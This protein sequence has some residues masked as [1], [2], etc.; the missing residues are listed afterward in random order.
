MKIRGTEIRDEVVAEIGRFAILWNYFEKDFCMNCCN[1][2]KIKEVK[3]RIAVEPEKIDVFLKV[4]S[5][6]RHHFGFNVSEYIRTGLYPG[7]ARRTGS[8][9]ES[10]MRDFM[11]EIRDNTLDGCL[12]I[13]YRIRNNLM[14]G[15]KLPKDLNDQLELFQSANEVLESIKMK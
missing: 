13:I 15:L 12:L 4:L 10:C 6:R 1:P 11:E 8:E 7:N 9:D 2:R 3:E 5:K 14:H